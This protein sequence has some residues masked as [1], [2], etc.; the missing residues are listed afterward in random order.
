M[1][2]RLMIASDHGGWELKE[3][4]KSHFPEIEW[5]DLGTENA[6]HSVDYPDFADLLCNKIESNNNEPQGILVCGSARGWQ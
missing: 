2:K 5:I 1:T 6:N 3:K 4:I